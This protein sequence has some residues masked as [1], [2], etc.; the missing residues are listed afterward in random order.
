MSDSPVIIPSSHRMSNVQR[1]VNSDGSA[2]THVSQKAQSSGRVLEGRHGVEAED[3]GDARVV[4]ASH[5]RVRVDAQHEAYADRRPVHVE[6]LG[7]LEQLRA[8]LV[9]RVHQQHLQ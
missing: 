7:H 6:R 8:G 4:V 1:H 5:I 3:H 9:R 2:T